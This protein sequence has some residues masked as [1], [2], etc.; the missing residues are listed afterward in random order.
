M[1]V[2]GWVVHA[3]EF[4]FAVGWV[5]FWIYWLVSAV[6]RNRGH[7]LVSRGADPSGDRCRAASSDPLGSVPTPRCQLGSVP[8]RRR[9]G[10]LR[11]GAGVCDLG[12][13][14]LGRNWG[15]P[16]SQKDEPELVTGGWYHV[17][18]H[19]MLASRWRAS[20]P[21]WRRAGSG[22]SPWRWPGCTSSIARQFRSAT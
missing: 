7:S 2:E 4:V 18:R 9:P 6:S 5:A 13:R 12:P 11:A 14:G 10:A 22:S 8:R 1:R 20:A 21:R 16:M 15:T 19:P 3:V 17:V